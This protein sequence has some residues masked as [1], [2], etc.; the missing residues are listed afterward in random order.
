MPRLT[1]HHLIQA[2]LTDAR[3]IDY[4]TR[5]V[6]L[7]LGRF[8]E[9]ET[10]AETEYKLTQHPGSTQLVLT[11]NSPELEPREYQLRLT[12]SDLDG[13]EGESEITFHVHGKLQLVEPLNYPNP[14]TRDTTVTCE[15]TR[16]AESLTVKIY[17]VTGRLIRQLKTEAPAGFIQLKWDGKDDDGNEV[18]NGVYYGKIIVKSLDDEKDQTHILK[19]MKLK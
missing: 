3:G 8:G 2:T 16:P 4:I 13:N 11:Y 10:I 5:P 15:L 12:A 17:T 9:F 19:M 7:A 1:L 14:F 18:A 6:Q